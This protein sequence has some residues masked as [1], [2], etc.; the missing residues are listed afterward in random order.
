M[1]IPEKPPIDSIPDKMSRKINSLA[2]EHILKNG[3]SITSDELIH[4]F[5]KGFLALKNVKEQGDLCQKKQ[6]QD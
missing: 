1:N 4:F 2:A 6:S 3:F 5:W